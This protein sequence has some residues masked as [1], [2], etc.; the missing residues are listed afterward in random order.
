M[1]CQMYQKRISIESVKSK[2]QPNFGTP[3][4]REQG[5]AL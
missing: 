5:A 3:V 1:I 2:Q 4:A